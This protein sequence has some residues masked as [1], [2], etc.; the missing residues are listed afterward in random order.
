MLCKIK[1]ESRIE[2]NEFIQPKKKLNALDFGCG[3]GL[4]SFKLKDFFK[5]ITLTDNSEGMIS[6]L[7]EKVE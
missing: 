4:L 7:Q 3:T 2:I 5:T 1:L 6:V